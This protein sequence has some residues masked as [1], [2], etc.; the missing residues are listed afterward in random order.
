MRA[1]WL[2]SM[3]TGVDDR[4]HTY[5]VSHPGWVGAMAGWS[6]VCQPWT[7]R[8]LV[9]V[10]VVVL[11]VRRDARRAW[12]ALAVLVVGS[13]VDQVVRTAVDRHRP[14]WPDPVA[15][16]PGPG[17]PSSHSLTAAL[18]CGILLM[19]AWPHL[20]RG[21]TVAGI[22]AVAIPLV[23]GFS[24]LALGVHWPSDVL[25]GWATGAGLVLAAVLLLRRKVPA[26]S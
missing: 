23:T 11:F 21:R 1:A 25:A 6:D 13:A 8:V 16:V 15:V 2:R 19:L 14:V 20:R 22:A 18:C 4:L 12:W 10:V 7:F 24:R 26:A 3:D 5:A 9:V 17:F